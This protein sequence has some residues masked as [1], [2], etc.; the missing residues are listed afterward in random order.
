MPDAPPAAG[1]PGD[2]SPSDSRLDPPSP[3]S[4]TAPTKPAPA[5]I[6]PPDARASLSDAGRSARTEGERREARWRARQQA[7]AEAAGGVWDL[8]TPV[9]SY[10]TAWATGASGEELAAARFAELE[11]TFPRVLVLHDRRESLRARANIDH[12]LVGPAGVVVADTKAWAGKVT[13]RD[14]ELYVGGHKRTRA[15]LD[16]LAQVGKVRGA[17]DRAGVPGV[18]VFGVLHWTTTDGVIL[19]GRLAPR[20]V[21]LLDA[22]GVLL[23][24]DAGC[25]LDGVAI[26]AVAA[27]LEHQLPP[28]G[29][30][31][32]TA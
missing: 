5:G 12:V 4:G 9:P 10:I 19:D 3:G 30:A 25:A 16:V 32:S 13:V 18:P 17:L 15:A 22:W 29:R 23:R 7:K 21:P 2:A 11:E 26:R 31:R 27:V 1:P 14:N 24:A 8:D 28:A 6:S 20:G